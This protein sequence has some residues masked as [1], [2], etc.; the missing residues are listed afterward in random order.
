VS[1]SCWADSGWSYNG[2]PTAKRSKV[3][4]ASKCERIFPRLWSK[5]SVGHRPT[6][7]CITDEPACLFV[8]KLNKSRTQPDGGEGYSGMDTGYPAMV[9]GKE[10]P[11]AVMLP[12]R[13]IAFRKGI[14][15]SP[16]NANKHLQCSAT[17]D[18]YTVFNL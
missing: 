14:A 17:G 6:V 3:S 7:D 4:L 2:H 10:P 16:K 9:H 5:I 8:F 12:E 13:V 15:G 18:I 1:A 11:K